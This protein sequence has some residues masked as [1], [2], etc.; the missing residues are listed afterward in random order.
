[1]VALSQT[2]QEACLPAEPPE[3]RNGV[4]RVRSYVRVGVTEAAMTVQIASD[5]FISRG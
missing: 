2:E 3:R 4:V 1:M 5:E